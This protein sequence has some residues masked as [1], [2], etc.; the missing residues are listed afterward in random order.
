[1]KQQ[2]YPPSPAY[3]AAPEPAKRVMKPEADTKRTALLRRWSGGAGAVVRLCE[4][5]H[6]VLNSLGRV[7]DPHAPRAVPCHTSGSRQHCI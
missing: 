4:L 7:G 3:A 5:A 6:G 2:T 1:M